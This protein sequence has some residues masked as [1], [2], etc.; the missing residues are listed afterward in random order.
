L[1]EELQ[2]GT[3]TDQNSIGFSR[4]MMEFSSDSNSKR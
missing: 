4:K 1:S 3:K 2:T